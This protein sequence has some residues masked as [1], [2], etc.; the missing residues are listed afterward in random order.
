LRISLDTTKKE[1][2]KKSFGLD[3][4][5]YL[6][7]GEPQGFKEAMNALEGLLWKEVIK[8]KIDSIMQNHRWELV[9]LPPGCKHLCSKWIFN[10]KMKADGTIDKYKAKLIIKGYRQRR[11]PRLL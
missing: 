3:F 10:R 7:E 11:R 2:I 9:D 1:S 5:T 6:P 4:L 8:S